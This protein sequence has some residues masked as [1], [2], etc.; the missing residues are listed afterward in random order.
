SR[1]APPRPPQPSNEAMEILKKRKEIAK[2]EKMR[3]SSPLRCCYGREKAFFIVDE[4]ISSENSYFLDIMS[5]VSAINESR[6]KKSDAEIL[7]GMMG[8]LIQLSMALHESLSIQREMADSSQLGVGKIFLEYRKSFSQVYSF[9]FRQLEA[10]YKIIERPTNDEVMKEVIKAMKSSMPGTSCLEI[11]ST[12][13][14]PVQRALKYP[15]LLN[16]LVK[17]LPLNHADHPKL[18]EAVKQ[19]SN[20]A[21]KMNESRRRRELVNKY[22]TESKKSIGDRISTI[23]LH[24]LQKKSS[25]F[26]TRIGKT[27]G[28]IDLPKDSTMDNLLS[29]LYKVERSSVHFIYYLTVHMKKVQTFLVN[30]KQ[31][32]ELYPTLN[33]SSLLRKTSMIAQNWLMNVNLNVRFVVERAMREIPKKL[34]QKREDKLLDYYNAL[35]KSSINVTERKREYEA[36]SVQLTYKLPT[37]IMRVHEALQQAWIVL[38]D[39][40]KICEGALF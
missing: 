34:V 10:A 33:S 12:I 37:V 23:N 20:L 38:S 19:M 40:H 8:P 25:R 11:T 32:K 9:Y 13:C 27:I 16:E 3:D 26:T 28:F 6:M 21:S 14:R 35:K 22:S 36:L 1:Q 24:S 17:T 18:V 30:E 4:L 39:L 2:G 15:L 29:K 31:L 5:F 7:C